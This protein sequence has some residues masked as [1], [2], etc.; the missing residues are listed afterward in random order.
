MPLTGKVRLLSTI[1]GALVLGFAA[2]F[3]LWVMSGYELVRNLTVVEQRVAEVH[4][5]YLRGQHVLAT[6]RTSVLLGS[7]YLRDALIDTGTVTREY[8][9]DE[10]NQ[11]RDDIE[12]LLPAYI[13]GVQSPIERQQWAL[14]QTELSDYWD[15]RDV[16]FGPDMPRTSSE[17]ANFLRRRVIPRRDTILR[18]VDRLA[19]LQQIALERHQIET[20]LL[21]GELKNR[22]LTI[23][24]FSIVLGLIVA[25]LATRHVGRLGRE[26]ERG[27]LADQQNKRDLERLSARL[28]HAQE[29]ERRV[30]ARELHDEVG[31]AL[32]A[33]KMELGAAHRRVEGDL[34]AR[35]SLD[36]ARAIAESALQSVRD[37][38]QLL[39]PSMLDDLGLPDTVDTY[40]RSF[41]K[42]TGIRAQ[43]THERMEERLPADIEV[44][45]YRI[46]QEALTNVA[47][48]SGASACTVRL[49]RREGLLSIAIEDDGRGIDPEVSLAGDARR[50][51]GLIG[52]RE[53][54]AALSGEFEVGNRDEGGTRVTV[55]LP[56]ETAAAQPGLQVVRRIG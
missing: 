14:L 41:S 47:K 27:R 37:M 46:V 49:V 36:E 17:S 9:R 29:E 40:L 54:A 34:R 15:S 56:V 52:M 2:V 48:H 3:A 21:Y 32:T 4:G 12:Q 31:Q 22:L 33:I 19:A 53:R 55:R 16:V 50:G 1:R 30:I 23:G 24:G 8:Y 42:R 45:V 7:V 44:G 18:I 25:G 28:V 6:I 43:L 10:L 38:S 26:I 5:E 35:S 11:I 39:H 20:S 13:L 51:L